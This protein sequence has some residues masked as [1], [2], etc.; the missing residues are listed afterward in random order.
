MSEDITQF[1]AELQ[2]QET[3]HRTIANYE[4]DLLCF[5]RWF[6]STVGEAFTSAAVTPTDV[7]NYKAHMVTVEW[8]K[9]ATINRRLAALRKF[10]Q[11]AKASGHVQEMPT[12][13][14]K[15]VQS[16][17]RA[18][19]SIEKREVDRL[20]RMAEKDENKR[21]LAILQALRHTGIRVGELCALKQ[22]DVVIF[23]R[24]GTLV[25]RSGKGGKHREIPLNNDAGKAIEAYKE[26]R[27]KVSDDHPLL[28]NAEKGS[29][30][31]RWRIS[32]RSMLD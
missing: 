21:N 7:R 10:F 4:S 30:P 17:P 20:I 3:A 32:S 13:S 16:V 28:A 19:K 14:V 2:R 1:T 23:E 25:V 29:N 15:A 8:R 31:R 26:V 5:A 22:S 24:K 11:W 27:P 6:T 12:D 9:P 18:P